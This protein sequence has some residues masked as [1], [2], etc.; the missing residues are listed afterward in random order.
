MF[1]KLFKSIYFKPA[2]FLMALALHSMSFTTPNGTVVLKAGTVIPLELVKTIT[3]KTARSGQ[4]VDFRVTSDGKVDGK[5]VVA[6]GSI[7]QGQI[8]RAKKNGLL[9]AEGELEIAVK[10][11]KAVDGTSVY[12]SSSNLA[13]EGSNKV[14]LSVVVT[15]CCLFG[16]LIKGG[17][18]EIPAGTQVQGMVVSNTDINV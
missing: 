16:N 6:A 14:V 8:V 13:D 10:S 17:Q 5:T 11:I 3:S 15:L 9:G 18:A 1:I 12:L 4:L 7:A 2:L